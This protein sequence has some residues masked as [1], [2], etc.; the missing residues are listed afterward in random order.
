MT[1]LFIKFPKHILY[2]DGF[3]NESSEPI[4]LS[5][6]DKIIYAYMLD[7]QQQFARDKGMVHFESQSTIARYTRLSRK[8]INRTL[9]KFIEQGVVR[10]SKVPNRMGGLPHWQYTGVKHPLPTFVH[11]DEGEVHQINKAM[12]EAVEMPPVDDSGL[13]LPW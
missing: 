6:Y 3:Y 13:D 2:A 1:N 8:T 7:K 11:S 4:P 5:I 10:A 12:C 9:S